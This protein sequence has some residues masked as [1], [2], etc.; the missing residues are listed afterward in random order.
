MRVGSLK[1]SH[2]GRVTE[3]QVSVT[4]TGQSIQPNDHVGKKPTSRSGYSGLIS[5]CTQVM[6]CAPSLASAWSTGVPGSVRGPYASVLGTGFVKCGSRAII[7]LVSPVYLTS[8]TEGS[9][10]NCPHYSAYRGSGTRMEPGGSTWEKGTEVTPVQEDM[11]RTWSRPVCRRHLS[12]PG[13]ASCPLS[14]DICW[15]SHL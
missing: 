13:A 3:G 1:S 2:H 8:H 9:L 12:R 6:R 7:K 4:A 15:Q 10:A 5:R 11:V 14:L